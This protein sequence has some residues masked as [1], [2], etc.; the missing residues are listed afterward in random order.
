MPFPKKFKPRLELT[1]SEVVAP[2]VVWIC[3]CVCGVQKNSCGWEGWALDS[4]RAEKNGKKEELIHADTD[5]SCPCCG[6]PLFRTAVS[7]RLVVS[8]NQVPDMVPGIH[9]H[10]A[11]MKYR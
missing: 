6:K 10:T 3:Y 4:V 7:K 11:P 9:Y 5:L 1:D 2:N 8:K